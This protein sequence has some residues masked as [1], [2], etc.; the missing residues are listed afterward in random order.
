[1]HSVCLASDHQGRVVVSATLTVDGIKRATRYLTSLSQ[2]D[3]LRASRVNS[4]PY[5]YT[6]ILPQRYAM[7]DPQ[8]PAI[9]VSEDKAFAGEGI[10][11]I[12][13]EE[14]TV[15]SPKDLPPPPLEMDTNQAVN[16]VDGNAAT[17]TPPALP[18]KL[19]PETPAK[20]ALPRGSSMQEIELSR[21]PTPS[22]QETD[23]HGPIPTINRPQ[24]STS[25]RHQASA[26][27]TSLAS[28]SASG[29]T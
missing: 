12:P 29:V 20:P 17:D 25:T 2:R 11:E 27:V 10:V 26:S 19:S 23:E 3:D 1:M 13:L 28:A 4:Y 15:T 18:S 8:P 14:P 22:T 16:A 6:E 9:E 5:P 21:G 7:S 24:S